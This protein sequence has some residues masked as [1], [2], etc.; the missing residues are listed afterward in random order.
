MPAGFS[1]SDFSQTIKRLASELGFDLAGVAGV[2]PTS[3][4]GFFPGWLAEGRAGEMSYLEPAM[5]PAS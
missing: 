5:R 3:E 4:H 1:S 2:E